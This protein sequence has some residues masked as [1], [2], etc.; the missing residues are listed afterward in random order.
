MKKEE[1]FCPFC[2]TE[3]VIEDE[4]H[5][6]TKC[7]LYSSIRKPLYESC[8]ELRPNFP[9]Y[10]DVEKFKFIMTCEYLSQ[11]LAKYVNV[12]MWIRNERNRVGD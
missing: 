6:L 5:F 1:R 4:V 8:T 12:G 9:F 11:E 10:T 7:V 3:S 2:C